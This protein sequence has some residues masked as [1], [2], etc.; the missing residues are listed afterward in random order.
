MTSESSAANGDRRKRE[1]RDGLSSV[2]TNGG[3]SFDTEKD[4][5][6]GAAYDRCG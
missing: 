1:E 4:D 6:S 3:D 5:R 2:L